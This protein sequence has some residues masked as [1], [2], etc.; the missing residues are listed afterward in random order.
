MATDYSKLTH[1]E[2]LAAFEALEQGYARLTIK[3]KEDGQLIEALQR[4]LKKATTEA[5]QLTR[6]L[7]TS[8]ELKGITLEASA[9]LAQAWVN[10]MDYLGR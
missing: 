6:S 1:K 7:Y 4:Q 9:G 10:M 8:K 2:L 5:Q 3:V